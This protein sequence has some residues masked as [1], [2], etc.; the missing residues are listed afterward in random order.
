MAHRRWIQSIPFENCLGVKPPSFE[1]Q[2][3]PNVGAKQGKRNYMGVNIME[4][5]LKR[6]LSF[7]S[8]GGKMFF[9]QTF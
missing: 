6:K 2:R 3:R 8:L 7:Y 4:L 1:T 5:M 9:M